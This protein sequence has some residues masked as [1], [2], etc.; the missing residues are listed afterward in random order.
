MHHEAEVEFE[1]DPPAGE[2]VREQSAAIK[3]ITLEI[4]TPDEI[5]CEIWDFYSVTPLQVTITNLYNISFVN[6]HVKI[7]NVVR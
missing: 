1:E 3:A 6:L 4:T 7:L 5:E 2:Q